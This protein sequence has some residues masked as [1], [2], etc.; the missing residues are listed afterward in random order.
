MFW[1]EHILAAFINPLVLSFSDRYYSSN[2]ISF[3]NHLFAHAIFCIYQRFVL[4]PIALISTVNLNYTL[5][6][7][8]SIFIL[9]F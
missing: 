2:I 4:F 7:S 8:A 3:R 9:T 6:P 5:C 1:I